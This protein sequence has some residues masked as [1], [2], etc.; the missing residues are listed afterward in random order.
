MNPVEGLLFGGAIA[1][2]SGRAIALSVRSN[3]KFACCLQILLHTRLPWR[4]EALK[5]GVVEV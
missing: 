4:I 1:V 3:L 5:E 2:F